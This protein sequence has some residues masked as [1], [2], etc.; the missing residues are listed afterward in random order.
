MLISFLIKVNHSRANSVLDTNTGQVADHS[1][2]SV[3]II[4]GGPKITQISWFSKPETG[5]LYG[6]MIVYLINKKEADVFLEKS[7]IKIGR[8]I[9]YT[10]TWQEISFEE[11]R[12]FNYQ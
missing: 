5:N 7:I 3:S 9:A 11:K 8:E 10:E 4:N 2:D 1:K 12:C 6:S